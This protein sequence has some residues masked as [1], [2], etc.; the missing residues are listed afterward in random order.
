MGLGLG[1]LGHALGETD[2]VYHARIDRPTV[3]NRDQPHARV[4]QACNE[5][6]RELYFKQRA[7][8]KLPGRSC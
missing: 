5:M 1:K 6:G 4:W 7:L 8:A 3:L 2:R